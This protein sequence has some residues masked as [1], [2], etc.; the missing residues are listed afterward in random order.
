[1]INH[2]NEYKFADI[3]KVKENVFKMLILLWF[4]YYIF[5]VNLCEEIAYKIAQLN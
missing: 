1:M 4:F 5:F 3:L 2:K